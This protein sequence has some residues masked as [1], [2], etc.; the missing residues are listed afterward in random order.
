MSRTKHDNLLSLFELGLLPLFLLSLVYIL[1]GKL[2]L[3]LALPPGYASPIFPPAGI[4][5]AAAFLA[6]RRTWPFIF[7]GSLLLNLWI[8]Y[9]DQGNIGTTGAL[10]ATIIALASLLQAILGSAMLRKIMSLPTSLD[11][12]REVAGFLLLAPVFCLTSASLSVGG[13]FLLGL[14]DARELISNWVAWWIGDTLGA[15]VLFP[16]T[17][18]FTAAPFTLWRSRIKTVALPISAVF[19]F[20]VAIFIKTS[21]WEYGDSLSEFKQYSQQSLMQFQSKLETQEAL[22]AQ[23]AALFARDGDDAVSRNEFARFADRSLSRYPMIQALSYAPRIT[24]ERRQAF[25]TKQQFELTQFTITERNDQG[26]LQAAG[27]RDFYYPVTFIE[28]LSGNQE[29]LGFDLASNPLRLTAIVS[30]KQTGALVA[31]APLQLVQEKQGQKGVLLFMAINPQ[32]PYSGVVTSVLRM[33][34]FMTQ[35]LPEVS[36]HLYM[37]LT[38]AEEQSTLYDNFG[39]EQPRPLFSRTLDFG[40][41]SYRLETAPTPLYNQMHRSWQS[42]GVLAISVLSTGLLSALLLLSTGYTA[43]IEAQVADRT[44]KLRDSEFRWKFALEGAGDGVWDWDV[45]NGKVFFSRRWKEMLGYDKEEISDSVDEW[46]NRLHPDDKAATLAA[47]QANLD[48]KTPIYTIEHRLR[49]RDGSW[50]WILDRGMVVS[51]DH[52][53]RPLRVIGTQTDITE[54][55]LHE[56]LVQRLAHYDALTGLPNRSLF[57]DRFRQHLTSAKRDKQ[58]LAL[59]FID[60]DRFKPV[61][62]D[63]GHHWGDELLKQAATRMQACVREADTVSRIGGDEFIVLLPSIKTLDDAFR[64]AEKIRLALSEPFM[65]D[66]HRICISS[67]IGLALYPDDG[68]DELQL[69]KNADTAMYAAKAAGRDTIQHYRN[70]M[71]LM[72]LKQA[73]EPGGKADKHEL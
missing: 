72:G 34:E 56:Q 68:L 9:Q 35:L 67:S 38:D 47:L 57:D 52:N 1:S 55:K 22:L 12:S 71:Q 46:K 13:L 61:N 19:V 54:R 15:V 42:W 48:G 45:S 2:G 10:V 65:L 7:V 29:A 53:G 66:N 30:A 36:P 14:V 41:R 11:N 20:F 63:L 40:G 27:F 31:S 43:R 6:G 62:D 39:P 24:G 26:K 59:M 49:C 18:I 51:R 16:L 25:I 70:D 50:K 28:P 21:Q 8:G 32:D 44:R 17:M 5:L 73:L 37:R 33:G 58:M 23:T 4:A 69:L 60:L 3:M 64:V